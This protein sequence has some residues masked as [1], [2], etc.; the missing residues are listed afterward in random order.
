[1]LQ[2]L[3]R[4]KFNKLASQKYTVRGKIRQ[5]K[6]HLFSSTA[7]NEM[8]GVVKSIELPVSQRD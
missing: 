2:N 7:T 4:Y 1:M 6:M 5:S 3:Y 8:L